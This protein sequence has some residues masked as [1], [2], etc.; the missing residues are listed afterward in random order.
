MHLPRLKTTTE[1]FRSPEGDICLLRPSDDADLVLEGAGER[2]HALVAA[3][4][5]RTSREALEADYGAEP[6]AELIG[7]L[8]SEG[9]VED[10]SAYAVLSD[11]ERG[12][13]DRQL[14]YFA[15]LAPAGG[16]R[17]L[18]ASF[19]CAMRGW[20]CSAWAASEAGPR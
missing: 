8:E 19:A 1:V 10:A 18:S 16:C 3:L 12:R 20:S 7:L 13:Y 14:R 11:E 2:D 15:D 9:L 5:G 6:V 17:R 4:D